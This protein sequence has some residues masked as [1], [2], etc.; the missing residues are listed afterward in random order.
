MKYNEQ[1]Q[2]SAWMR[3]KYD[4]LK[5]DNFVCSNCLCDNFE[6]TLD[7]HHIVYLKGRMAWEYQDYLLV[8]LCRECHQ[9]EHDNKNTIKAHKI[10]EWVHRLVMT[11][12][13]SKKDKVKKDLG[14]NLKNK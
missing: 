4:I 11:F 8:T 1:L 6:K 7:V 2:T 12:Y 5:R 3:R 14:Y 9:A 13:Q 10:K